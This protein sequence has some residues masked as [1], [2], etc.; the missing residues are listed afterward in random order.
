MKCI[1]A[2]ITPKSDAES[3]VHRLLSQIDL[4]PQWTVFH[5][6][7]HDTHAWKS[8]TEADFVLLGPASIL[9][10]E[11]KGGG[12]SCT[13]DGRWS[14][15][16]RYE[17]I[18]PLRESPL[19]Q[20]QQGMHGLTKKILTEV[21]MSRQSLPQ[22][23]GVVFPDVD[24]DVNGVC[25]PRQLI[26]DADVYAS[27]AAF[28]RYLR[29]LIRY[30]QDQGSI[31]QML[32]QEE[33]T[34]IAKYLRPK[35]DLVPCLQV[36]LGEVDRQLVSLTEEQYTVIDAL[37]EYPRVLV[38]GGAGT[39][40]AFIAVELG[41]R[42]AAGGRPPLLDSVQPA[43]WE[44][45]LW[46]FFL[47]SKI[48]A[49][50]TGE[51]DPEALRYLQSLGP[52]AYQQRQNVRNTP[53]IVE[54][55]MMCTG[56]D[57]GVVKAKGGGLRV[58]YVDTRDAEESAL[59]LSRRLQ[60]W[61]KDGIGVESISILSGAATV[62]ASCVMQLPEKLKSRIVPLELDRWRFGEP[63]TISWSRIAD[64][65]G[66]ERRVIAITDLCDITDSETLRRVLYVAMTRAQGVLWIAVQPITQKTLTSLRA[67][68]LRQMLTATPGGV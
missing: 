37:S 53:Q 62:E 33:V 6:V 7:S 14:T 31:R 38:H 34:A 54:E 41:R 40:K 61:E 52:V 11:V 29:R 35:F 58:E 28:E 1:P 24:F 50:V 55:S 42:L 9:V 18:H 51:F 46:W 23:W 25:L 4:G 21:F 26:A 10:L 36:A 16:D 56:A 57:I 20:A 43:G 48:Q 66:W 45:K 44:K 60:E 30:W 8:W 17:E 12:I 3:C 59:K 63:R 27:P 13:E 32:E 64:F 2:H 65:K 39:G 68:Y 49:G 47:D 22:G 67:T 5:S 19:E 15:T